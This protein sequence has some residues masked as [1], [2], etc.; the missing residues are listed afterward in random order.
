MLSEYYG[1]KQTQGM[2]GITCDTLNSK[3]YWYLIVEN[4]NEKKTPISKLINNYS[5][6][7]SLS[8]SPRMIHIRQFGHC[9][10]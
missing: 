2:S 6:L 1:Q 8:R 9:T 7:L 4:D 5:L 10:H 3:L